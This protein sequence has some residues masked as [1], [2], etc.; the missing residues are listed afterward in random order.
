MSSHAAYKA[1]GAES[2]RVTFRAAL[3]SMVSMKADFRVS[4]KDYLRSRIVRGATWSYEG[5]GAPDYPRFS[6]VLMN[7]ALAQET[8]VLPSISFV[9]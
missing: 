2:R 5:A 9:H 4:V 6:E 8:S 7:R 1:F 3:I